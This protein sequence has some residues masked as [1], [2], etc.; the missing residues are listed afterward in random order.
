MEEIR[1]FENREIAIY[2]L[3]RLSDR[4]QIAHHLRIQYVDVIDSNPVT[5]KSRLRVIQDH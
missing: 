1:H 2:Q 3:T 4:K 5:L